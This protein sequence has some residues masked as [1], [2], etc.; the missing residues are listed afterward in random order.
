MY[1]CSMP[2]KKVNMN[3]VVAN[4]QVLEL[5]DGGPFVVQGGGT[6]DTEQC[7]QVFPTRWV[8][9]EA[10]GIQSG[11]QERGTSYNFGVQTPW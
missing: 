4:R 10:P 6:K 8:H 5:N 9:L 2:S 7:M 3:G 1:K 11:L